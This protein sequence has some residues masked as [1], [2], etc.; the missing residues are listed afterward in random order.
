M[1]FN[2]R[3]VLARIR[4]DVELDCPEILMAERWAH[5]AP[6]KQYYSFR[7]TQR[8]AR[9]TKMCVHEW[10]GVCH[11]DELFYLFMIPDQIRESDKKLS[12]V[13][14]KAWTLFARFGNPQ[15]A[16]NVFWEEAFTR[17]EPGKKISKFKTKFMRLEH[18]KYEMIEGFYK[19]C[20]Q[21]WYS[22]MDY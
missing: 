4:G 18:D 22:R 14:I 15:H 20:E 2:H 6:L 10:M 8:P 7:I 19:T 16:S 9:E 3:M 21:F 5:N 13:M 11:A 1:L 12:H 17:N